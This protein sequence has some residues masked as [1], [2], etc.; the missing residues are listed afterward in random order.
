MLHEKSEDILKG[1]YKSASFVVQAIYFQQT[2]HYIRHQQE[3]LS[4][5]SPGEQEI[6]D[7]FL[8]LKA[9]G[10]VDFQTMS[11]TLFRWTQHW[12]QQ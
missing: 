5:V 10:R 12:I 11:E 9:G 3:L 8:H 6:I 1:L 7:T 2:G 4:I